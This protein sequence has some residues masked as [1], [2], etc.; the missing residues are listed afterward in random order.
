MHVFLLILGGWGLFLLGFA[1]ASFL[2]AAKSASSELEMRHWAR[3]APD[4]ES[5]AA[6]DSMRLS[7]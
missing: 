4:E 7:A 6:K 1:V 3:R 5:V 2:A